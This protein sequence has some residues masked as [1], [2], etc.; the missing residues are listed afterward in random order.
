[1]IKKKCNSNQNIAINDGKMF[2]T[3]NVFAGVNIKKTSLCAKKIK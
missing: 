1:M 3:I 2:I